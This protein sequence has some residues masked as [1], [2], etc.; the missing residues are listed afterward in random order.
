[1]KQIYHMWLE[2][3]SQYHFKSTDGYLLWFTENCS[4]KNSNKLSGFRVLHTTL[5]SCDDK[6]LIRSDQNFL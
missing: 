1:M 6:K 4:S 2:K 5:I 3:W